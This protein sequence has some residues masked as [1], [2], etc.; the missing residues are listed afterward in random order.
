MREL[1]SFQEE[2]LREAQ[3]IAGGNGKRVVTA[4]V[5]PGGGKSYGAAVFAKELLKAGIVDTVV[6]A[7]PRNTLAAQAAEDLPLRINDNNAPLI[8]DRDRGVV[9][10]AATYQAIDAAVELHELTVKK[11]KTLLIVDEFHHL[12]INDKK[13]GSY[14]EA[15]CRAIQRV[16]DHCAVVLAMSGTLYRA[17]RKRI[18][19]VNYGADG[20][21]GR[22]DV[23]Y[24][25][26]RAIREG[27]KLRIT[28]VW[29]DG[30]TLWEAARVAG[31]DIESPTAPADPRVRPHMLSN[32]VRHEGFVKETV[33]FGLNHWLEHRKVNKKAQC[34]VVTGSQDMAEAV[35]DDLRGR[36]PGVKIDLAISRETSKSRRAVKRYRARKLDVLVSVGMAHEG[37]DAPST[38]HVIALRGYCSAPYCEQ[39][40]DRGSRIDFGNLFKT[41]CW[42]I[43]P[44]VEA[45]RVVWQF[46]EDEQ[47]LGVKKPGPPGPPRPDPEDEIGPEF[48]LRH[49]TT[50]KTIDLRAATVVA[51][52]R[53]LAPNEAALMSDE[54]IIAMN[55]AGRINWPEVPDEQTYDPDEEHRLRKIA[56][57]L[58]SARDTRRG[59]E[60][61]TANRAVFDLF[62]KSRT[63]MGVGELSAVVAWLREDRK[64]SMGATA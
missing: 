17:D 55:A 5:T 18:A 7:V 1:R 32:L 37:L 15:W 29:V 46:I 51:Q 59:E 40:A 58:C 28:P 60:P 2:L 4:A 49:A 38:T 62:R 43:M 27:A 8:R 31:Q 48:V 47:V 30:N 36:L 50:D 16:A 52:F 63:K 24:G 6:W 3:G 64:L 19:F 9:G 25:R 57:R 41:A 14:E 42:L 34:L 35:C 20:K 39:C 22:A 54:A 45:L 53:E 23:T 11:H 12:A 13:H 10:Y 61:G 33:A 21:P 56:N 26:S 44:N